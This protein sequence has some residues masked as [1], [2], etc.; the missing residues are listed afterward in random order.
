MKNFY[1]TILKLI[2]KYFKL[3]LKDVYY[4]FTGNY[5]TKNCKGDKQNYLNI[6]DTIIN[7]KYNNIDNFINSNQ[8]K[9]YAS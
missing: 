2:P 8:F 9:E 6:Y 5:I 7:K 3:F 4:A 1:S